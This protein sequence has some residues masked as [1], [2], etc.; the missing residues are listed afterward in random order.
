M[1]YFLSEG[2]ILFTRVFGLLYFIIHNCFVSY[3]KSYN[4]AHDLLLLTLGLKDFKPYANTGFISSLSTIS[5]SRRIDAE[6]YH[7]KHYEL[8]SI[9]KQR[10]NYIKRISDIKAFNARGVQPKYID[11]GQLKVINSK[12]ITD[13]HLDY[14]NFN[15]TD[16]SYW[17]DNVNARVYKHDILIY[18][19]GANIGRANV[20]LKEE[21]AL[22]SNHVNILRIKEENPIY[23]GFVINSLIGRMQTDK[24]KT[25]SAQAELYP[26]AINKFYIPFVDKETEN[27]II[28]S[29][30]DSL[31]LLEK[32]KY[33][34]RLCIRAVEHAI[35][36]GE[37]VALEVLGEN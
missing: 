33:L 7:P 4:E 8:L 13:F 34:S 25:G 9:L 14:D 18:T 10:S 36:H 23:V 30:I 1:P 28:S 16:M 2:I 6:H 21:K 24:Y 20:Y 15:S 35:E 31:A 22:A 26:F 29:V 19:T 3:S 17:A 37:A 5:K 27:S 11:D 32:S 12:H